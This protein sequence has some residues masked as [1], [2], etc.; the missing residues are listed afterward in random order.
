MQNTGRSLSYLEVTVD[1]KSFTLRPGG[2]YR[3]Y[4]SSGGIKNLRFR[5]VFSNGA[6][7]QA[8]AQLYVRQD[9][10]YRPTD[11][12]VQPISPNIIGRS[13]KDYFDYNTY[14]EGEA[15]SYLQHPQSKADGKLRNVV[16]LLDGYDPI[17]ER[18]IDRIADEVGPLL[19]VLETTTGK[20]RDVVILNFITSRRTVSRYGSAYAQEVEGGA[21]FIERNALVLVELLN[22]LKPM[23]ADPTQ[24]ITVLGPSM[25]GLI[26]RYALAGTLLSL[27]SPAS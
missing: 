26:S 21:D 1:N 7:S 23:L 13:W 12:V 8:Q 16:V 18:K 6:A 10:Y 11:A 19:E 14:G 2:A 3:V 20:E 5:A 25:G 9:V 4:F 22:R 17:D 24:K 15:A 27:G